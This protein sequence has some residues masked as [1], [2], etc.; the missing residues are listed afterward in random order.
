MLVNISVP[1]LL[2]VVEDALLSSFLTSPLLAEENV[3]FPLCDAVSKPL[4][5][6]VGLS[7][8]GELEL[9]N[10]SPKLN[11]ENVIPLLVLSD[12]L[13]EIGK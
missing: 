3:I 12:L 9:A 1:D 8:V 7:V 11:V 6:L 4:I 10:V 5:E 13:L 2:S